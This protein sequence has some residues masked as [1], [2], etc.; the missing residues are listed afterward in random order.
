MKHLLKTIGLVSAVAV[1]MASMASAGTGATGAPIKR[2][3]DVSTATAVKQYLRSIGVSPRGVVIQRGVRNYAGAR[4]PGKGWTCTSTSQP[5][6][7]V[8]AAGG[9]NSFQC[10]SASCAV[11]QVA[12]A[13]STTNVARC[14]RTTGITQ[15]CSIN[16]SSTDANN[17]AIVVEVATKTSGLTQNASQTAQIVQTAGSGA[18]TACVLQRTTIEGSTVKTGV[19]V[20]VTLDAHQ[21]ISVT[22]DSASGGNATRNA[23]MNGNCLSGLLDQSQTLTS[24]ATGSGSIT[25]RQNAAA[26]GANMVLDIEQNQKPGFDGSASGVNTAAFSQTNTLTAFATTATGPVTQVQSSPDGGIEAT[27]NQFSTTPSTI[28][29]HQM[30]TQCERA[31]TSG[32][33]NCARA[34]PALP[35]GWSQTQFGPVRKGPCCSTQAGNDAHVFMVDQDSTQTAGAGGNVTQ[36]NVV[37]GEC[38]TSATAGCTVDQTTTVQGVTTQN[39]QTAQTVSTSINCTGTECTTAPPIVFDGSPGTSAPPATLGP[40]TMT[41]FGR[42]PRPTGTTVTDVPDDA[43]TIMFSQ[44]LTHSTIGNGWATWS[45]GYTGDVYHTA[46]RPVTITLPAGTRAFYFY[47]EPNF[48]N[49]FNVTATAQDGT[50]SGP[51]PVQGNSGAK[52]FGFYATGTLDLASIS[53]TTTADPAASRSASSVS[54]RRHR[55]QSG[56]LASAGGAGASRPLHQLRE[57]RVDRVAPRVRADAHE[58]RPRPFQLRARPGE[59]AETPQGRCRAPS[60]PRRAQAAYRAPRSASAPRRTQSRP[61]P[62]RL[63][64]VATIASASNSD[65]R[66][67]A[68]SSGTLRA[69]NATSSRASSSR[70]CATSASTRK[71][72][73]STAT[74]P[75]IWSGERHR[76]A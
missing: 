8:A 24:T 52:Y 5:V 10:T 51:I 39:T 58:D 43:G 44:P 63:A 49:V 71:R 6:V 38:T 15:S 9:K 26:G 66:A 13:A 72:Y 2:G 53:V 76:L 48:F 23:S 47:A 31:L 57:L 16:Q 59:V 32:T 37:E 70:S 34:N 67:Y 42:D 11:V 46:V 55:R 29:A 18:N 69:A 64:A 45:H 22:Q 61:S 54:Q 41:P 3:I 35:A 17:Q 14:I 73:A 62:T 75:P 25:Q 68:S 74:Q 40:Y 21:S 20:N 28:D 4:C 7:Q 36:S 1:L 33:P 56:D 50:T 65:E 27:V 19:P 60:A 30:E 12:A